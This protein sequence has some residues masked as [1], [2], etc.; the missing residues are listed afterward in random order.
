MGTS[1]IIATVAAA[2][3]LAT[4]GLSEWRWLKARNEQRQDALVFEPE[5]DEAGVIVV[6][7]GY[8]PPAPHTRFRAEIDL[9]APPTGALS[10]LSWMDRMLPEFL[11]T[12]TRGYDPD[13]PTTRKLAALFEEAPAA[14]SRPL[15][16]GFAISAPPP[17]DRAR[18]KARV[19]DIATGKVVL[20]V[21]RT[22]A[23]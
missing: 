22:I 14:M 23:V 12:P 2:I 13:R 10:E 11:A 18:L 7:M 21:D 8:R 20:R 1:D 16:I 3:A 4:L 9:V 19:I 6:M 17:L 5:R 15:V